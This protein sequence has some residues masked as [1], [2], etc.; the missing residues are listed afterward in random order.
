M[1]KLLA[2]S[3]LTSS[4]LLGFF[5]PSVTAD[6][7]L[8]KMGDDISVYLNVGLDGRYNSNLFSDSASKKDDYIL[9]FA[10][11]VEVVGGNPNTRSGV[12]LLF[13]EDIYFHHK[14]SNVDRQDANFYATGTYA[15]ARFSTRL[16]GFFNE[17]SQNTPTA[18][19]VGRLVESNQYGGDL[20]VVYT[21]SPKTTFE[22]GAAARHTD[23][24]TTGANL[25]DYTTYSFPVDLYYRYSPKLE[26][27]PSYRMRHTD[28]NSGKDSNDHFVG[29][30]VRGELASKVTAEIHLGAQH[31]NKSGLTDRTT[32]SSNTV[33]KWAATTKLDVIG[34]FDKDF[35]TSGVQGRSI[36]NTG[37]RVAFFYKYCPSLA[38][39]AYFSYNDADYQNLVRKD[40]TIKTSG[41]LRYLPNSYVNFSAGYTYQNNDSNVFGSSYQGHI[42]DLTAS[43]R[44]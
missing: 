7:P 36:E 29:L 38:L 35:A 16:S 21:L 44:Y 28:V 1:K 40:K 30:A 39:D 31:R 42:V 2:L 34:Y 8:F 24:R 3:V 14:N 20:Q 43:L 19:L 11:G 6:S 32:F 33:V 41:V 26:F 18:N 37:G 9:I 15:A 22:A 25:I 27:G 10:P 12:K 5:I 4:L 17:V 23:Y 13:R